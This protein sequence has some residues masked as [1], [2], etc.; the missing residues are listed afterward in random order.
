MRRKSQFAKFSE[1][2]AKLLSVPHDEI[3][4]KLEAEKRDK[5][6]KKKMKTK[7]SN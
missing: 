2:A 6:Q 5:A 1:L 3:K 7:T 4:A